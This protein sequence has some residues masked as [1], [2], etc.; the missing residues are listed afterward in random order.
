MFRDHTTLTGCG[1][2]ATIAAVRTLM[3]TDPTDQRKEI[4]RIV[5]PGVEIVNDPAVP[6]A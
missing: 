1:R 3:W 6:V 2:V 4:A 5:E